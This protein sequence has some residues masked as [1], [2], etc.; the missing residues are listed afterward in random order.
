MA[1]PDPKRVAATFTRTARPT[2]PK[3]SKPP[4]IGIPTTSAMT[5][6]SVPVVVTRTREAIA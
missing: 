2:R 1:T 6:T 4:R 3:K 5:V